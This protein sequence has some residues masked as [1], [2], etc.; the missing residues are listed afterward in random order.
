MSLEKRVA[1]FVEK[2]VD[3]TKPMLLGLSGGPDSICLLHLLLELKLDL[4]IVH[5]DHAWR[6]ESCDEALQLEAL[7]ATLNLP[8]HTTRL[9]PS[10]FT[11]NLEDQSRSAR[12][13]FF[14]Q[15]QKKV[16]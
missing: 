4:H 15:I 7:A 5:V 12:L 6:P 13:Q 10:T 16:N 1:F 3:R 8:F 2:H 14:S 9:D 11:G